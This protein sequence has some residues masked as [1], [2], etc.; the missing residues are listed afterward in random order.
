ML[1]SS[2][3]I[4]RIPQTLN[5]RT[6]IRIASH[7]SSRWTTGNSTSDTKMNAAMTGATCLA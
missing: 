1:A 2:P 7:D 6:G 4:H 3:T 5:T